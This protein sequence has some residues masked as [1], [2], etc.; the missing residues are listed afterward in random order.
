MKKLAFVVPCCNAGAHL[1][2]MLA[3]LLAQTRT[4]ARITLVD[5]ASDDGSVALAHERFGAAVTVD[6]NQVRLG[7][8]ANWNKALAHCD[9]E[10]VCIAHQDDVYAPE[11]AATMVAALDAAPTAAFAHC[12]A[13]CIDES[14]AASPSSIEDY[15]DAIWRRLPAVGSPRNLYPLLF[16]GNFICCSSIVF[17]R[18]AFDSVGWFDA[19][20][21]FTLDWDMSFRMLRAGFDVASV[22]RR[23]MSYRRHRSNASLRHIANHDRYREELLTLAEARTH[24]VAAGL[25]AQKAP[26]SAAVRNNLLYDAFADLERGAVAAAHARLAFGRAEVPGF[27]SDLLANLVGAASRAGRVGVAALRTGLRAYVAC[28]NLLPIR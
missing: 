19:S 23:L 18:N 16:A 15:K 2:P 17:R 25:L 26:T 5:D 27:R 4:D 10:Y 7:I 22:D 9:S 6:V 11:F 21:H 13:G 24:G 3:S 28:R 12:R 8:A 1:E 14:G 20:L